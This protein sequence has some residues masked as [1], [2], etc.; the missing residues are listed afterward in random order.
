M[1]FPQITEEQVDDFVKLILS[2][3]PE[4][5]RNSE[6]WKMLGLTKAI[7]PKQWI[8]FRSLDRLQREGTVKKEAIEVPG[9]KKPE[10]RYFLKENR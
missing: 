9:R 7:D 6:V 10:S 2:N 4:G 1:L 3:H 8:S 5:L